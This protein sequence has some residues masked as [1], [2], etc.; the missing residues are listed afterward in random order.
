MDEFIYL[1]DFK[2]IKSFVTDKRFDICERIQLNWVI[3]TDNNLFYYENRPVQE[4]FTEKEFRARIM[5]SGGS[6]QIKSIVRGHNPNVNI[7]CI[8]VIDKILKSCDGFGRRQ[9]VI[10]IRTLRSD[11]EFYYIKHY[12]SKSTEEFVDKI[13]RKMLSI[14]LL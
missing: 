6:Q 13:L 4:R 7:H 3:Y 12:Y 5:K 8:H 11:Y 1:K 14:I 9:R 2:D 10:D